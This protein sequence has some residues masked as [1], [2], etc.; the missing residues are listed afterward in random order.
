MHLIFL[1]KLKIIQLFQTPLRYAQASIETKLE[2]VI[3]FIDS[4]YYF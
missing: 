4:F 3:R 2:I 1:F